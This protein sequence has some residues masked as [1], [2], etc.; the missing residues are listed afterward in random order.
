M[1]ILYT[2]SAKSLLLRQTPPFFL[3]KI[4]GAG[5]VRQTVTTFRAPS[6][7]GAFFVSS[8]VDTR[9]IT[10]EGRIVA[11]NIDE[12]FNLRRQLLQ[13]FTPKQSGVLRY[14]QRKIACY[15]EEVSVA[16]SDIFRAPTFFISLLCPSTFFEAISEKSVDILGLQK[17]FSF[18]LEIGENGVEFGVI[19]A[20]QTV[21][22]DNDGDVDCGVEIVFTAQNS[23]T[24]PSITKVATGEF[25]KI[26]ST[27][28]S[29]QELHVFTHFA[30]KKVVLID[31]ENVTNAF[32]LIDTDSTFFQLK[33]GANALF[34]NAD[35]G[36]DDL[37]CTIKFTPLYLGV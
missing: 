24:N 23:V 33:S 25:I 29:G 17:A 31:G 13:T 14:R 22:I 4:D 35:S 18:P 9:N 37:E 26:N 5:R 15:V 11:Q 32:P 2:N 6:Q 34:Y 16:N 27:L 21:T 10:I 3:T 36:L 30:N 28:T 8:S 12:S 20:E 19:I 1:E 7:D